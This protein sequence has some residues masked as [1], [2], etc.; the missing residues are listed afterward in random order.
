[1]QT[2]TD[3]IANRLN[4]VHE[5]M[6]SPT[7]HRNSNENAS[8]KII[9]AEL[10]INVDEMLKLF[11]KRGHHLDF[12]DAVGVKG[13]VQ[14]ITSLVIWLRACLPE[15]TTEL[16]NQLQSS[17]LNRYF[18]QGNG[19]FA[20]GCFFTTDFDDELAFFIDDQ[21]IYLKHHIQRLVH[22][23]ES[24]GLEYLLP[25]GLISGNP[26]NDTSESSLS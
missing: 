20:N 15:H 12:T 22:E 24:S 1:M 4:R 11:Q 26:S 17:R 14:D 7:F 6:D 21:R 13:K 18:D 23:V 2:I 10:I 16:P 25:V 19:Y 3:Q 5:L 9:F 8:W